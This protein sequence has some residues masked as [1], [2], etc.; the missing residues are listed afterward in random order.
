ML[1]SCSDMT[2]FSR[3]ERLYLLPGRHMLTKVN[4]EASS[5]VQGRG[6]E[7]RWGG[8][9]MGPA[10]V[11]PRERQWHDVVDH[12]PDPDA[13]SSATQDRRDSQ[14]QPNRS[15]QVW[16]FQLRGFLRAPTKDTEW[17]TTEAYFLHRPRH[18]VCTHPPAWSDEAHQSDKIIEKS[19]P[20]ELESWASYSL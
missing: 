16:C 14:M 12:S 11:R 2:I 15:Q 7:L 1:R 6:G 4:T 19:K 18:S 20:P 13:S 8:K 9:K 10:I 5:E 3:N 17:H